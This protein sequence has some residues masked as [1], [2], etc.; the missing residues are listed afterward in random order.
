MT[1]TTHHRTELGTKLATASVILMFGINGFVIGGYIGLIPSL[2]VKLD[3]ST[4]EIAVLLF[5]SGVFGIIGMQL[6]GRLA[7]RLGAKKITLTFLPF[8][9]LAPIVLALAP[10]HAVALV[11]AGLLGFGNGGMDVAMNALGVQ[12]EAARRRPIMSLFHALWSVGNFAGAALVLGIAATGL[13]ASGILLPVA[14]VLTVLGLAA[15]GVLIRI[16]PES[17]L[18]AHTSG[19]DG[20]RTKIPTAGWLLGIMA[21]GFGLGEGTAMDWSSIHVVDVTHVSPTMG[22]LGIACVAGFMVIIRLVGDRL[23]ARFGRRN[24]VR[25]GAL[26]AAVGYAATAFV[27]PLPLVLIG[28]SLVGFGVGMIAPQVYAVAGHMGG[29]RVLAVVVTFGYATFLAGPAFTGFLV[30]HVGIQH[31]MLVPAVLL[32]VVM[33]FS[34]VMP[35][36][37]R[38]LA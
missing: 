9:A 22:A 30:R 5:T 33:A 2:R 16:A 34:N 21:I 20:K 13:S 7:D 14:A 11:G 35:A 38:D 29:G 3:L 36:E 19:E 15:L 12:V 10:T 28:W 23:V 27:T 8:V 6:G 25:V 18:V 32:L 37:D 24:V 26:T 4:L 17:Q 1:T 31:A